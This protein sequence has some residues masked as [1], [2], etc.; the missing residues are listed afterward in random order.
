M[1]H[2]SDFKWLYIIG[3]VLLSLIGSVIYYEYKYPCVYGH[4]EETMHFIY[5]PDG[6][7]VPYWSN[8]FVCDCRTERK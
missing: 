2:F 8:D 3:I 1:R 4:Y 7:M 5:Q 6:T